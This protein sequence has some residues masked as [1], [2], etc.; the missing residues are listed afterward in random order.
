MTDRWRDYL[1]QEFKSRRVRNPKYSLRAYAKS[2]GIS[3]A[4]TSQLLSGKRKVRAKSALQLARAL[5]LT[6]SEAIAWSQPTGM[7]SKLGFLEKEISSEEF[8]PI[9]EWYYFA[10]LGLANFNN[11]VANARW[12]SQKLNLDYKTAKFAFNKLI[13][14][15]FIEVVSGQ[16]RQCPDPIVTSQ[17]VPSKTIRRFHQKHLEIATQKI[18]SVPV[19]FREFSTSTIAIDPKRLKAAQ[20][21]IRDFRENLLAELDTKNKSKVYTF[22]VQFYPLSE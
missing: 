6:P 5:D 22:A 8:S 19:E 21:L 15:E 1:N 11:N 17:D 13:E 14:L 12:I 10:I 2:L 20:K 9:S 4:H 3:P 7:Q 16:F 18:D